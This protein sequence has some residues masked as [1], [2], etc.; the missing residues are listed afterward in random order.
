MTKGNIE[1]LKVIVMLFR[2]S[3]S[4]LLT[5]ADKVKRIRRDPIWHPTQ[6]R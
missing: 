2:F 1:I 4:S 5:F 6:E 3:F